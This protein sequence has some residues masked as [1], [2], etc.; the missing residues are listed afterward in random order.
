MAEPIKVIVTGA[1]GRM[2]REMVAGLA[3]ED[4]LDL[5]GGVDPK[6][7][8]E[9]LPLPQGG[10]LIPLSRELEPMIERVRPRVLVDFTVREAAIANARTALRYGVSPVIGTT[11]LSQEDVA[12]VAHLAEEAGVGA[13]IA[14][15]FAIGANLMIYFARV[16]A[17]FMPAAEIIELHH[18]GKADAP[19]GTA[20][21]TAR[22]MREAR[23]SD[24][25]DAPTATFTLDGVRGGVEGGVRVHSVRLPGLVAHQEVI[26][27]GQGQTLTI[28]HDSMSRESFLPGVALAIKAV[29]QARGLIYG[30]DKIMG[31][32]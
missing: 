4:A 15:N 30:L 27:G 19:S 24:L 1:L 29:V 26:F 21:S 7:V 11:G 32:E 20:L 17:R 16:A 28:R 25:R 13:V 5:A 8:E 3:R 6:A 23:G 9:Y 10:G 12:E 31:L 2:G 22:A 14:P 18:D